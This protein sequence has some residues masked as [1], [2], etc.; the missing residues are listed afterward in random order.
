[1]TS[2]SSARSWAHE[3]ATSRSLEC[4]ASAS[5]VDRR[6]EIA[7]TTHPSLSCPATTRGSPASMSSS[8]AAGQKAHSH[9]TIG[10]SVVQEEDEV[11]GTH[12]ARRR[13]PGAGWGSRLP[14]RAPIRARES[15]TPAGRPRARSK[16]RGPGSRGRDRAGRG[17][18]PRARP[19]CGDSSRGIFRPSSHRTRPFGCTSAAGAD[20][21]HGSAGEV[22]TT[23]GERCSARVG[24][25][26]M[27][28]SP[29][30]AASRSRSRWRGKPAMTGRPATVSG[31]GQR[32]RTSL[33][34]PRSSSLSAVGTGRACRIVGGRRVGAGCRGWCPA[35]VR[36]PFV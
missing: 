3:A 24:L 12:W 25:A 23:R 33:G 13:R 28:V 21:S 27:G 4:V 10:S 32:A 9:S 8:D 20:A 11:R 35:R 2:P 6:G 29:V 36:R 22:K 19:G 1:M 17:G 14:E 18:I 34:P 30:V 5:A 31:S 16:S 15:P 26:V 7:K